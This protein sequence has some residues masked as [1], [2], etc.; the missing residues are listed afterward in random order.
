SLNT[1]GRWVGHGGYGGQYML[2]D[3]ESGVV[4][5]AFSVVEDKDAYPD[6]YWPLMINMLEEIGELPFGD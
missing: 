2:C 5:V 4:G 6:D 3:L 1:S